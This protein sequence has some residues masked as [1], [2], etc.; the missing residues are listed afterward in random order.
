MTIID[1]ILVVDVDNVSDIERIQKVVVRCG[2][3]SGS[4]RQVVECKDC[5][6]RM[7]YPSCQ[8]KRSND[9]CS[10]G[11]KRKEKISEGTNHSGRAE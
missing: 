8:G 6:N 7:V 1:G 3:F 5:R 11:N 10:R 2:A 4:F 9:F